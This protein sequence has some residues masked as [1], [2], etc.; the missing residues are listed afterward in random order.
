MLDVSAQLAVI[1][2]PVPSCEP[3]VVPAGWCA[4]ARMKD[5]GTKFIF[6]IAQWVV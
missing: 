2:V 1:Q 3:Y 4:T 5:T 6:C